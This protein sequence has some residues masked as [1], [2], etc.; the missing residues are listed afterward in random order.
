[1]KHLLKNYTLVL[2]LKKSL[3]FARMQKPNKIYI[4]SDK[5]GLIDLDFKIKL[6]EISLN[7]MKKKIGKIGV[8]K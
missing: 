5:Y 3:K 6:Y 7:K 8:K 2:F 1:M 4:L